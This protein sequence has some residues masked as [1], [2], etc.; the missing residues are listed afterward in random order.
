MADGIEGTEGSAPKKW[1]SRLGPGSP[2]KAHSIVS[3]VFTPTRGVIHPSFPLRG[4]WERFAKNDEQAPSPSLAALYISSCKTRLHF[5][6]CNRER[7]RQPQPLKLRLF[8]CV[9]CVSIP[10]KPRFQ[11]RGHSPYRNGAKRI[12]NRS[13]RPPRPFLFSSFLMCCLTQF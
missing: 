13:G 4:R 6:Q 3:V 5:L 2:E 8:L 9:Y 11:K 7:H 10:D 12:G 1:G